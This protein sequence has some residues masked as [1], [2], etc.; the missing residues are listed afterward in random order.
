MQASA[1]CP[2]ASRPQWVSGSAPCKLFTGM[3]A[4][5]WAL[6]R[7]PEHARRPAVT[8]GAS[9]RSLTYADFAAVAGRLALGLRH[10]I[11]KEVKSPALA[12]CCDRGLRLVVSAWAT[13]LAGGVYCP[14]N[15][16]LPANRKRF[17]LENTSAC[18]ILTAIDPEVRSTS[19]PALFS[20][21]RPFAAVNTPPTT[22]HNPAWNLPS[23]AAAS[24]TNAFV[25][26]DA[27][28]SVAWMPLC[29]PQLMGHAHTAAL[30]SS[31]ASAFLMTGGGAGEHNA[32][33]TGGL[34]VGQPMGSIR[35]V[36]VVL[37]P[38]C[39]PEG[40][41][42]VSRKGKLAEGTINNGRERCSGV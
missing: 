12:V 16:L 9:G 19:S 11:G 29:H 36:D 41:G 5:F 15:H 31:T 22:T 42:V 13:Q 17:I 2:A 21:C 3:R 33:T 25:I 34:L 14:M 28:V 1:L 23:L 10:V 26:L 6:A 35:G 20:P 38:C 39:A 30:R 18:A 27:R 40:H 8:D 24:N 4:D 7:H 37:P 32:E